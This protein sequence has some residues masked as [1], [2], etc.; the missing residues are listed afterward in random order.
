MAAAP[1]SPPGASGHDAELVRAAARLTRD[2]LPARPRVYWADLL[3]S[4]GVGY[5]ALAGA[6]AARPASLR[7]GCGVVAV[8]ALYRALSFIHELTHLKAGAVPGFRTGW[9]LLVGVPLDRKSVV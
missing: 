6:A 1:T 4:A 3:A 9:N 7:L 5:A 2:L 8:L